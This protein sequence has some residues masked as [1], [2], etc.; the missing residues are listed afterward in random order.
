MIAKYS[1]AVWNQRQHRFEFQATYSKGTFQGDWATYAA[2]LISAKA[3]PAVAGIDNVIVNLNGNV[4]GDSAVA[5]YLFMVPGSF[6]GSPPVMTAVNEAPDFANLTLELP[7]E[8]ATLEVPFEF[9][10]LPLP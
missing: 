8:L 5:T 6:K 7:S 10:D 4:T 2:G 1:Q 3:R 9:N